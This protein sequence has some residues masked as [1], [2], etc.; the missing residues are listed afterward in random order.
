MIDYLPTN[1]CTGC[2]LAPRDPDCRGCLPWDMYQSNL[3]AIETVLEYLRTQRIHGQ[4]FN[5]MLTKIREAK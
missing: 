2:D 1:P 4:T 3:A 5:D